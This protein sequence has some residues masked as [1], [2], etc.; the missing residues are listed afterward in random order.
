MVTVGEGF[1]RF[2]V[3]SDFNH[4]YTR[5]ILNV[6]QDGSLILTKNSYRSDLD[7]ES[8]TIVEHYLE[9]GTYTFQWEFD[10]VYTNEYVRIDAIILP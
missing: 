1:I 9:E 5:L 8:W 4:N 10:G 6:F 2:F 3:F 7:D